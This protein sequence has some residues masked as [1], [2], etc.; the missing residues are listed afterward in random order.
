MSDTPAPRSLAAWMDVLDHIDRS[1]A[2]SLA[3]TPEPAPITAP[4]APAPSPLARLDERL[5][6]WQ[7]S[8][9]RVEKQATSS[10][11]RLNAEHAAL[12]EWLD[13]LGRVREGFTRWIDAHTRP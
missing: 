8:L 13:K 12:A 2:D 3:R 1:L 5:A 4:T 11:E 6:A 7:L 10:T 9:E